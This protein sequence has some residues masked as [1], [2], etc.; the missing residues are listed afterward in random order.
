MRRV[1]N[2]SRQTQK[3][4]WGQTLNLTRI[5]TIKISK[6]KRKKEPISFIPL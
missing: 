5:L 6:K 1:R 2:L 4:P 3:N